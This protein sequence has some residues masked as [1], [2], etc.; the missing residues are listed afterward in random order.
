M[1]NWGERSESLPSLQRCNFVCMTVCMSWMDRHDNLLLGLMILYQLLR[2]CCAWAQLASYTT[3]H[4][5]MSNELREDTETLQAPGTY[6]ETIE[7]PGTYTETI[8]ATGTPAAGRSSSDLNLL[9]L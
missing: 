5:M 8:E 6:T 2:D 4:C 7:A 1:Y 3:Q 9:S